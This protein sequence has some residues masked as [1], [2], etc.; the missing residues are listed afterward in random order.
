[1]I[2]VIKKIF[3]D[4][5]EREIKRLGKIVDR[6]EELEPFMQNMSDSQLRGKTEEF[7][8]RLKEGETLDDILPEAFAVVREASKRVL[9]MRHFRVQLIGGIVLHQGRIAEMKPVKVRR[10]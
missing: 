6:I 7:K 3:G 8:R 9:G 2:G 5:N 4:S 10:W 1:M